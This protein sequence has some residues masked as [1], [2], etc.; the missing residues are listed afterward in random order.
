MDEKTGF[1]INK[2]IHYM[3]IPFCQVPSDVYN[4]LVLA[5]E[6][7]IDAA[8]IVKLIDGLSKAQKDWVKYVNSNSLEYL[9]E[10]ID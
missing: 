3:Q 6:Y 2:A 10:V 5:S 1:Y 7:D 9:A 4:K 8:N